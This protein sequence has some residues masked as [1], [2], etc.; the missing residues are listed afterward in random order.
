MDKEQT[1][2]LWA[3]GEEAWN[4]WALAAVQGKQQL[5]ASG[6]WLADWFGEGQNEATQAWLADARA[7]FTGTDFA[8][9]ASFQNL[10]F[11]GPTIFDGAHFAGRA[12]FAS[13]RFVYLARFQGVGFESEA[14]FKQAQF[15]HLT[16]FDEA[17]FA[18]NADFEKAEF[19]RESSGP[20]DPAARF[21]KTLFKSRAEFRGSKFAGHAEFIR[22]Q[23]AGN[24]RFD[25]AE[26][27][28]EANFEGAAFEG[29]AGL[30]K[31]RFN[32]PV[33]FDKARFCNDARF[34]ETEFKSAA[35]FEDS[36]FAGKTSFRMAKFEGETSFDRARFGSD[37]RFTEAQFGGDAAMRK[38]VFAGPAEFQ[39][40]MFAKTADFSASVFEGDSDFGASTF[41]GTASFRETRFRGNAGFT[42]A[43]FRASADFFQAL[44]KGRASF[45]SADF[46][47]QATFEA[48]QS[49][50][51]FALAG[52]RFAEVP[53]F[54]EASLR[55]PPSL[56]SIAITDPLRLFTKRS[57][58][59][60][61][62]RPFLLRGMKACGNPSIAARYRRLRQFAAE[63]RDYE[64]ERE[65]FAQEMRA[66]RFFLDQPFGKGIGRFWFGWIYGGFADFGRSFARPLAVWALSIPLFALV[67]LAAREVIEPGGSPG[68]AATGKLPPLPAWP[69]QANVQ[70]VLHWLTGAGEW[71]VLSVKQLFST[72]GCVAGDSSASAEA[73]FLSLKNSLFF[74][75]WESQD[76]AR[77][78]YG[79]LYG[80]DGAPGAQTLR[81][82]LSIST[83]A[84]A[85][86]I[87][88]AFLLFLVLLAI[89]NILKTR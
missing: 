9:D 76:A 10:V 37:A 65:F 89:R 29:T 14:L 47:G 83:T 41:A 40:A 8:G 20:L 69:Q 4:V 57:D 88:S 45:R 55:E 72:S 61:D 66:R 24:A 16:V 23:F 85:Q 1:R 79:C 84:I 11:P 38:A 59:E 22:A 33:K 36:D 53:S 58:G 70:A 18:A 3:K 81:V 60:K 56:D 17:V 27:L 44:F 19:L 80:F 51:S 42:E 50:G 34:G 12:V 78:V 26:F 35:G 73:F 77:R 48:I 7:D 67:Y 71:L 2:E 43:A 6:L 82:P 28:S 75:G 46:A 68:A 87:V 5:E 25:E 31:A 54:Q 39:K 63:A 74:L 86:N 52:S 30:V 21:Q 13:A 64:R 49:R 15:Y 32:G 62:P